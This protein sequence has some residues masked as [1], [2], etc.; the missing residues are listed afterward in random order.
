MY[1]PRRPLHGRIHGG[2][3]AELAHNRL[4]AL[5][6]RQI[7][8]TP[9]Q[10]QRVAVVLPVLGGAVHEAL[11]ARI[12]SKIAVDELLRLL[13]AHARVSQDQIR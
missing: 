4:V 9:H 3:L 13:T 10:R 8:P 12:L 5:Q 2:A 7:P 1:P 6:L 11:D